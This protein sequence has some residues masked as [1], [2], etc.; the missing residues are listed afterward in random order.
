MSN[1]EN[2]PVTNAEVEI[3]EEIPDYVATR[4]IRRVVFVDTSGAQNLLEIIVY[5]ESGGDEL[6]SYFVLVAAN[7]ETER[8][9]SLESPVFEVMRGCSISI[10]G[11]GVG[12]LVMEWE[13]L[14]G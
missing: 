3:V 8:K 7:G 11:D 1:T 12:N 2:Y 10:V 13:D 5:D 4:V 14:Q 6:F 9:G